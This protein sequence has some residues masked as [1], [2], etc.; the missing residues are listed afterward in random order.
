VPDHQ[1][2]P[3]YRQ[4]K[5]S[6]LSLVALIVVLSVVGVFVVHSVSS[7]LPVV[8]RD[9]LGEDPWVDPI[10]VEKAGP[11]QV[12]HVPDCAAGP[13]VR[14]ML[15]DNESNPYWQ[16][17]GPPTAMP[18]FVVGATPPGWTVNVPYT[19]PRR[20]SILRLV[21]IRTVKGAAGVRFTDTD[22]VA[23]RVVS[24]LPLSRFTIGGYQT[25]DVC[26]TGG[27]AKKSGDAVTTTVPSDANTGTLPTGDAGTTT[28]PPGA[29]RPG[30]PA[31]GAPAPGTPKPGTPK[32]PGA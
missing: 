18:T 9:K 32:A 6:A 30:A 28:P 11:F 10:G 2:V 16:V 23:K 27:K 25:A 12:A 4:A 14:I 26:G 20:G 8:G 1:N 17:S 31:P 5:W 24:M 22:V 15:W 29:P 7:A 3:W 19:A 13:I 21:I